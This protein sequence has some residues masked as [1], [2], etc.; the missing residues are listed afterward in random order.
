MQVRSQV[1]E[2]TKIVIENRPAAA[3][4][5]TMGEDEFQALVADIAKNGQQDP[6]YYYKGRLLDGRIASRRATSLKSSRKSWNG[7]VSA[8][9]RRPLSQRGTCCGGI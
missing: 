2:R 1:T 7:P 4:F 8:A 3:L 6:I 9:R 5:A